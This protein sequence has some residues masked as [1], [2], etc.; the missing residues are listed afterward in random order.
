MTA[1]L[2]TQAQL[3]AST[4]ARGEVVCL[5]AWVCPVASKSLDKRTSLSLAR[6]PVVNAL[7]RAGEGAV[8]V[9]G[10][11]RWRDHVYT[12]RRVLLARRVVRPYVA[13]WSSGA[14]DVIISATA[15]SPA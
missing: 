13:A 6:Q 1:G 15:S 9:Y 7:G 12:W 3:G 2:S 8:S 10:T 4:G 11:R 5:A 14:Q